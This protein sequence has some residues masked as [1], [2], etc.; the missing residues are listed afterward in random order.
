MPICNYGALTKNSNNSR[1]SPTDL[2]LALQAGR[3][4]RI[5]SIILS[6]LGYKM[7]VLSHEML[8]ANQRPNHP[9]SS[10][11]SISSNGSERPGLAM[12][13]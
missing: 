11:P 12:N 7:R 5:N 6:V 3:S 10:H 9:I 2:G 4:R 13:R 8:L 1:Q